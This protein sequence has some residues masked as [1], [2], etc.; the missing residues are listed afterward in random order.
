LRVEKYGDN[1]KCHRN[2]DDCRAIHSEV[3]A[4]CRAAKNGVNLFGATMFVTRYPCEACARAIV[5][6][7]IKR[8]VYGRNQPI[9]E[10]TQQI[11]D[12]AGVECIAFSKYQEDD[13]VV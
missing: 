8:V 9:S 12:S 10:M 7:G 6:A 13:T 11:F 5:T 1:A 2:P 4:I 3:D